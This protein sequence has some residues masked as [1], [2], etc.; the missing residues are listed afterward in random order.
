MSDIK[1]RLS[2]L[3]KGKKKHLLTV[4]ELY[5]EEHE[6]Y[7]NTGELPSRYEGK[8]AKNIIIIQKFYSVDDWEATTQKQQRQTLVQ[9]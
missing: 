2:E 4:V 9:T 5:P 8:L 3:E 1:K 7:T 6:L